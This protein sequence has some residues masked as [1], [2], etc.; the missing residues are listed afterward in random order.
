M[1]KKVMKSW[2]DQP[3]AQDL[4]IYLVGFLWDMRAFLWAHSSDH[5]LT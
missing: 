5:A 1:A 4:A 2:E 3:N